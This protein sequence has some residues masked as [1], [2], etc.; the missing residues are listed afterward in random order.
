MQD[1][2]PCWID[3]PLAILNIYSICNLYT[4]ADAIFSLSLNF[5][6]LLYALCYV[7]L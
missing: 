4:V 6:L 1:K 5:S 2:K 7:S 3:T